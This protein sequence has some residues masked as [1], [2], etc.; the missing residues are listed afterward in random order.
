[1]ENIKKLNKT[2]F[3]CTNVDIPFVKPE[4]Q[5][6]FSERCTVLSFGLRNPRDLSK[7]WKLGTGFSERESRL[8][9][10]VLIC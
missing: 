2:I 3:H 5:N 6:W 7:S 4:F 1:M 10:N 8:C 9:I